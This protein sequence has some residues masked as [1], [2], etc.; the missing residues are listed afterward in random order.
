MD[1][2]THFNLHLLI[3]NL[4][5]NL[6]K[7]FQT[8]IDLNIKIKKSFNKQNVKNII[9]SNYNNNIGQSHTICTKYKMIH[10]NYSLH[11]TIN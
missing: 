5:Q 4:I 10:G 2:F 3:M 11:K 1:F 9:A 6:T 8:Y 7:F